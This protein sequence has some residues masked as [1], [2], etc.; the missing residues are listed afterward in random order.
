MF[1]QGQLLLIQE[2]KNTKFCI[3][4]KERNAVLIWETLISFFQKAANGWANKRKDS[5]SW[6]GV[7]IETGNLCSVP[8]FATD[9]LPAWPWQDG[10]KSS[11]SKLADRKE[12]ALYT[13]AKVLSGSVTSYLSREW[14][15]I[16]KAVHKKG[17]QRVLQQAYYFWTSYGWFYCGPKTTL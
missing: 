14:L 11:T 5:Y 7:R 10:V 2:H 9:R 16:W 3:H 13:F 8:G 1:V 15:L 17:T 6:E 12:E 4:L